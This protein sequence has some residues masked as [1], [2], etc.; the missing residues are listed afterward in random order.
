[1]KTV[2]RLACAALAAAC[3][4]APTPADAE[5]A[6]VKYVALGDSAAA[7]PLLPG[8]DP[9][10]PGCLRS[11]HNYPAV[12]AARIGAR[13]TDV[14]CS[15]ARTEHLT[16]TPQTTAHGPVPPQLAA[17]EAD[18][19]LVTVTVGAND[20]NL[21]ATALS[22]LGL[23][24]GCGDG[25][26]AARQRSL[27]ASAAPAW[28]AMLDAVAAR[29]PGARIV[30]VGYGTYTRPGG[31]P[32]RQP[33]RP[34]DADYLQGLVDAV[35]AAMAAQA[36]ARSI[37][38]VDIRAVTEGHDICASPGRAHYA[39]VLPGEP[40]APLHPTALGMRAIGGHVA[41]RLT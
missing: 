37:E 25:G 41:D 26:A 6:T 19:D 21:F 9:A 27:I 40:A 36:R 29:A 32:D 12:V 4:G 17:L 23:T 39:G 7:G 2:T 10:S 3:L 11:L 38:F 34:R 33:M 15:S 24:A 35:N 13:L 22:C 8:P 31:C 28:G 14:T 16:G 20:V 18:T 5:G 1:M 30:V